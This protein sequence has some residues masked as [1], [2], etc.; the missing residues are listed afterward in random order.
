M[1]EIYPKFISNHAIGYDLY[2][3]KSQEKLAQAISNH[4]TN[5]DK[6]FDGEKQPLI[7]R[8]IGLE[9]AWGCGKSNVV[10]QMHSILKEKYFFFTYDAWGHQEDLQRRSLLERLTDDLIKAEML[11]GDTTLK[12]L[13]EKS[14]GSKEVELF[15]QSCTWQERLQTLVARK[16]Y[17]RNYTI[18]KLNNNS[19]IFA[20]LLLLLGFTITYTNN[21]AFIEACGWGRLLVVLLPLLIF[22]ICLIWKGRKQGDI[23]RPIHEMWAFYSTNSTSDTTSYSI[24]QLE[25]SEKE[26]REWMFDL[27]KSLKEGMHLVIVFDNMDRLP[28]EKVKQLWSSINTFFAEKGYPR[29]WCVIP[30]DRNHLSSAFGSKDFKEN[31]TSHFIEKTFPVV[32]QV[33]I[34]VIT[35]YK[36]VFQTFYQQAFGKLVNQDTVDRVSATYRKINSSPNVRHIITFVNKLV[37]CYNQWGNQISQDAMALYFLNKTEILK[38]PEKV[39]LDNEYLSDETIKRL[40]SR[41]DSLQTEIS[42]LTYGVD[43]NLASQ[44]P[45]K[46]YLQNAFSSGKAD[47]IKKYAKEN[48]QFYIILHELILDLDLDTQ[49]LNTIKVLDLLEDDA[50]INQDWTLLVNYYTRLYQRTYIPEDLPTIKNLLV[51]VSPEDVLRLCDFVLIEKID[52]DKITGAE[53]FNLLDS[54][55]KILHARKIDYEMVNYEVSANTFY[56]FLSRADK[57]YKSYP[58]TVSNDNW[59]T[60]CLEKLAN[61]EDLSQEFKLLVGDER[62]DFQ[63]IIDYLKHEIDSEE[64][65][66]NSLVSSIRMI[67]ILTQGIIHFEEWNQSHWVSV[68]NQMK[69]D[70]EAY[71]DLYVLM[72]LKGVGLSEL[73]EKQLANLSEVLLRYTSIIDLINCYKKYQTSCCKCL[74][75]YCIKAGIT[76]D[77]CPEDNLL[78]DIEYLAQHTDCS[79]KQIIQYI[80]NWGYKQLETS[81]LSVNLASIFDSNTKVDQVIGIDCP[82]G[83]SITSK[84][85]NDAEKQGI[86]EF[87]SNNGNT[88]TSNTYWGN[89]LTRLVQKHVLSDTL[90]DKQNEIASHLL[91]AIALQNLTSLP[92]DSVEEYLV[93]H[94]EYKNVSTA[95]TGIINDFVNNNTKISPTSFRLLHRFIEETTLNNSYE[96]FLNFCMMHLIDNETCQNIILQNPDFYS[97]IM[98]EHLDSASELK[99]KIQSIVDDK[100]FSNKEFQSFLNSIL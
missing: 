5:V 27:D 65:K 7:P 69:P 93:T 32:Y 52:K 79:Y 63:K 55:Q 34:P 74:V 85:K 39:I 70:E 41:N 44:L 4:I 30:F 12:R 95:V 76:D 13:I 8:L 49:Y 56:E 10:A 35:D 15:T 71:I 50:N 18:P 99:K 42:A 83:K 80:N 43:M 57:D 84:F 45:L 51:R 77:S 23:W 98:R 89:V 25:P 31:V 60:L 86:S 75:S 38:D 96:G 1:A 61:D 100:N 6:Q 58:I 92:A 68:F 78:S 81:D 20:L 54:F 59:I 33:P 91:K 40:Y 66:K 2:E 28:S 97:R 82:L 9:G 73:A 21:T 90:S 36:K 17:T 87:V 64:T 72:A 16:S 53:I 47:N 62:F 46:R 37:A 67:K 11:K 14:D 29:I 94:A 88:F 48:A 24:S 3:G 26:F 19:K 22:F